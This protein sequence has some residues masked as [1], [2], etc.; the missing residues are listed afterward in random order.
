MTADPAGFGPR[1]DVV[2]AGG[3]IAFRVVGVVAWCAAGGRGTAVVV[4]AGACVV[5]VDDVDDVDAG[6]VEVVVVSSGAGSAAVSPPVTTW[7]GRLAWSSTTAAPVEVRSTAQQAA[8]RRAG[9]N[10]RGLRRTAPPFCLRR[11][12]APSRESD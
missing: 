8:A 7:V 4:V 11:A 12:E 9:V 1:M 3:G 5:D 2:G 10:H 6:S